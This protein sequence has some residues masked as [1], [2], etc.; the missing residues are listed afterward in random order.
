MVPEGAGGGDRPHVHAASAAERSRDRPLDLEDFIA[1]E[2]IGGGEIRSGGARA[3][4]WLTSSCTRWHPGG[5]TVDEMAARV[6]AFLAEARR[7]LDLALYDVRLPGP[8]GDL[9]A[10]ALREAAARGVAVRIAYNADHDERMFPPPPSTKP[11]LIEALP[12]PTCGIPGIPD[13]MHHK[14]VVRDGEAVWTGSTNWTTDSWTLQENLVDGGALGR[15]RRRVRRQ[16]RGALAHARR[17]PHRP[18]GAARGAGGRARGARLVHAR[19][20]RG[21]S[22]RIARGDR[23]RPAAGADRL[24]GDHRRAR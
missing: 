20:R 6:A 4:G 10:D 7:S 15:A 13:L 17:E 22:H 5:Q 8:A 2:G 12:F 21:L 3:G 1:R 14:Y 16:L 23:P 24:A 18:R 11:E 19:A 9:V